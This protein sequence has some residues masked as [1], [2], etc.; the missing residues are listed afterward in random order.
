VF[1]DILKTK[2]PKA[3]FTGIAPAMARAFPANA[4]TFFAYEMAMKAMNT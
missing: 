1:K 2:G 3:F 4:A